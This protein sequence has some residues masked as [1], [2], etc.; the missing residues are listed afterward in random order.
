MKEAA[1]G[2]EADVNVSAPILAIPPPPSH[3]PPSQ[4]PQPQHLS[5]RQPTDVELDDALNMTSDLDNTLTL[6]ASL[7]GI[8][9]EET[10]NRWSDL[11]YT[12]PSPPF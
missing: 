8:S 2:G 9:S 7:L 4:P 12:T 5:P 6:D 10:G 3:S 11:N 1:D